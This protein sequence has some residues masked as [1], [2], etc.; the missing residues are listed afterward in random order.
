MTFQ[1]LK[2][3]AHVAKAVTEVA[4]EGAR[5]LSNL[6]MGPS[7]EGLGSLKFPKGALADVGKNIAFGGMA[8]MATGGA[9][10][11]AA[12]AASTA[13]K[14]GVQQAQQEGKA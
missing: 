14:N 5:G 1:T 11:I 6:V 2:A 10:V 4:T 9:P 7:N 3:A 13:V 8:T 12:K